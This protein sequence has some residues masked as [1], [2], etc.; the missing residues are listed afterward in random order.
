MVKQ[1]VTGV[2]LHGRSEAMLTESDY[3]IQRILAA[4]RSR[5]I[6]IEVLQPEQFELV[7]SR[8]DQKSVLIDDKQQPLP[9][10]VIP[11][12][13]SATTYYA[14]AVLRQLQSQGVYICNDSEAILSV[15]DKLYMH[16]LL[17]GSRLSSPKTMLAKFPVAPAIV[18]R[19]LGFPLV[20]KNVTGSLGSGI[21]L[22][23]SEEKFI[24]VMELVY[25][26]NN[27]A[28]VILQEFVNKSKGRDLRVY[29][30]GGKVAGCME[31][32]SKTSFKAN[33]SRGGEVKPFDITPEIEWLSTEAAKLFNL[34]I[35]GVDLLFDDEGFKI[36]EVNSAP[37]FI[38]MERVMGPII[39]EQIIDYIL[40]KLGITLEE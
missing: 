34:D 13:G 25:T 32:S 9:D 21:Y 12:M 10:F 14:S 6:Q 31:R 38:G 40:I 19:E 39:A 24:D 22:C 20:I 23:E 2:I 30:I 35:A 8:C 29:I 3:S 5:G 27:R 15:K 17:A 18:K 26:Y 7:V 16:Q 36:C 28:N 37:G 1:K 33:V 4:A 11:R